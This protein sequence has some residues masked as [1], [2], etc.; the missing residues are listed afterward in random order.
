MYYR[1]RFALTLIIV[2]VVT[3]CT[4]Q[5]SSSSSSQLSHPEKMVVA[6]DRV[7][8]TDEDSL[9]TYEQTWELHEESEANDLA[10]SAVQAGQGFRLQNGESVEVTARKDSASP[11]LYGQNCYVSI[12]AGTDKGWVQCSWLEDSQ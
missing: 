2:S 11:D 1:F 8:F 5:N 6:G 10:D 9:T 4:G 12:D 3:A 7:A